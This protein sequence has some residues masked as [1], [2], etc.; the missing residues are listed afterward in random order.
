M[1]TSMSSDINCMS[2]TNNKSTSNL[3]SYGH[4]QV[5]SSMHKM[6]YAKL[7]TNENKME[8]KTKRQK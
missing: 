1:V 6:S 3:I 5:L 4:G 7:A 8:R 2:T